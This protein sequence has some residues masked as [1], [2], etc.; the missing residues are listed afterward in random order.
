MY[1]FES[2]CFQTSGAEF[3][4]GPVTSV[5]FMQEQ[6]CLPTSEMENK[7]FLCGIAE[8]CSSSF[9]LKLSFSTHVEF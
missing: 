5:Y 8:N 7:M 1:V 4:Q 2:P 3:L 6:T 9:S